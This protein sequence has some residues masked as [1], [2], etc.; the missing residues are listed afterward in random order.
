MESANFTLVGQVCPAGYVLRPQSSQRD[1]SVCTCNEDISEVLSCE[2]D[3]ETVV[4]KV[5]GGGMRH[6]FGIIQL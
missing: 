2:D 5:G 3:Q 6:G 1:I 4:I